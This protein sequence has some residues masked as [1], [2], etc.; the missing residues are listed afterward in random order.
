[1]IEIIINNPSWKT[2]P[3]KA[4]KAFDPAKW[5]QF[6]VHTVLGFK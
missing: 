3:L 5:G 6:F 2:T 1:M 4:N